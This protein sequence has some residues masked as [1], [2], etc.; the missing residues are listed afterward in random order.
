[1]CGIVGYIGKRKATPI[2]LD[3][4]KRLE[5]RGYD[6]AGLSVMDDNFQIKTLKSAGKVNALETLISDNF[7]S[8]NV[9]IAHTRW[10]THGIPS[11]NN[12]HPHFDC[13]KEIFIAHN[14]IIENYR[15]LKEK[16]EKEGHIFSSETDSEVLAH[17]IEKFFRKNLEEAVTKALKIIK[18]TYGL[19]VIS[20]RDPNK[21][22]VA[23]NSSPIIIGVGNNEFIV[24]SDASAIL[25]HT[26]QVIYLND[27]E[28]AS[29]DLK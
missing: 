28:I 24:A 20:S 13:K 23:R 1:M 18:G 19:V 2:L 21:I 15:E 12:A 22:V 5:Y 16:L 26:K 7:P 10:A 11:K 9:G 25:T 14:G 6:S 17:L 3:G 8:G 29:I 4:L 27:G